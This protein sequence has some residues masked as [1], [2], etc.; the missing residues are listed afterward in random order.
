MALGAA[1]IITSWRIMRR[2]NGNAADALN[3]LYIGTSLLVVC[4][5]GVETA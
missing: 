2:R 1:D 5:S 3:L 4:I